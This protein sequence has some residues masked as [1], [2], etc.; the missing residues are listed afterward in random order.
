LISEYKCVG[1][2]GCSFIVW[3]GGLCWLMVFNATFNTISDISWRSIPG[4]NHRPV[5]S[6]KCRFSLLRQDLFVTRKHPS[7][8]YSR[9]QDNMPEWDDM[10]IRGLLFQWAS[11]IKIQLSVLVT[12]AISTV[13]LLIRC[14]PIKIQQSKGNIYKS[15][16]FLIPNLERKL[17]ITHTE[18]K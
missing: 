5:T 16:R 8:I 17:L 10:S 13:K 3:N 11:T 14:S 6:H 7:F 1:Y 12:C 18:I 15:F 2:M 4:E 9:N